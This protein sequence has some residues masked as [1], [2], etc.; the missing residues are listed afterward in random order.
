MTVETISNASLAGMIFSCA[1]A[2][3]LPVVLAILAAIRLKAKGLSFFIG[4][5]CY[6]LFAMVLEAMLHQYVIRTVGAEF[7]E[8]N[9]LLYA[10]YGGLAAAV[11]EEGG[12]F[13]MMKFLMKSRMT[14]ENA[15]MFGIGHGG[16]ESILIVGL[17]Y[18]SNIVI[19]FMINDGRIENLL[20]GVDESMRVDTLSQLSVMWTTPA[21]EMYLA[22]IERIS[23]IVLQICFSCIVFRAV[24]EK[25]YVYFVY[26]LLL[27]MFV[28][29]GTVL[30]VNLVSPY[31]VELMLFAEAC[32]IGFFT[33]RMY[34]NIPGDIAE[35]V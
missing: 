32:V 21:A 34:K 9:I 24:S 7:F 30:M 3:L 5:L 19:A 1:I 27:H 17:T 11:F 31:I 2:I 13:F 29:T 20:A 15:V 16:L 22:G 35:V 18:F 8:K 33:Y 28:D 10:L 26:A 12:R 14:K 25:K 4:A 23:A 6:L